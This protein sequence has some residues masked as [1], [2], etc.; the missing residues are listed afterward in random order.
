MLDLDALAHEANGEPFEFTSESGKKRWRL[1]HLNELVWGAKL[2]MD[3]QRYDLVMRE[4]GERW[5]DK[6]GE[7][8]PARDRGAEL[9]L[10]MHDDQIGQFA[11]NYLAHAGMKPGESRASSR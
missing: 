7:W 10:G 3:A 9:F 6:T 2:A 8:V 11:A 4:V 1:P 5:D